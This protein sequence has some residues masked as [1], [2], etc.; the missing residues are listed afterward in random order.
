[1]L[2]ILFSLELH[3]QKESHREKNKKKQQITLW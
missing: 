3:C 2:Y 1:M